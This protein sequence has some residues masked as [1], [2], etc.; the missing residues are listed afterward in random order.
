MSRKETGFYRGKN[1]IVGKGVKNLLRL[2]EVLGVIERVSYGKDLESG[3]PGSGHTGPGILENNGE[4]GC[5]LEIEQFKGLQI[6]IRSRFVV[7]DGIR[8]DDDIEKMLNLISSQDRGHFFRMCGADK[9]DP[10]SSI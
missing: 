1:R 8:S 4:I 5:L 6:R 2:I 10:I 7:P 3:C 9:P